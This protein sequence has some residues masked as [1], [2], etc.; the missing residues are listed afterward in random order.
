M[1]GDEELGRGLSGAWDKQA[2]A[3]SSPACPF[4]AVAAEGHK[5]ITKVQKSRP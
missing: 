4:Q 1:L 2:P 3:M 5:D